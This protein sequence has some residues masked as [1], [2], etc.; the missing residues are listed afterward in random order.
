MTPIKFTAK[1][2]VDLQIYSVMGS[3]QMKDNYNPMTAQVVA[4]IMLSAISIVHLI[5]GHS[6]LKCRFC[7][8]PSN[9][10]VLILRELYGNLHHR[11]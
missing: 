8:L 6:P 2:P 5:C 1:R 9:D 10:D 3:E 4:A 7:R 11:S